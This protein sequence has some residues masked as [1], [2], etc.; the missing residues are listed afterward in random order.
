[1]SGAKLLEVVVVLNRHR[2]DCLRICICIGI[3]TLDALK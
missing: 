3:L 2:I 1:M